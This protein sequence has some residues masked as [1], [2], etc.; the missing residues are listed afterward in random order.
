[1]NTKKINLL[2][3]ALFFY[4]I[5]SQSQTGDEVYL[6]LGIPLHL[7]IKIPNSFIIEGGYQVDINSNLITGTGI[8]YSSVRLNYDFHIRYFYFDRDVSTAYLFGGYKASISKNI[9]L[10]PKIQL[11][12]SFIDYRLVLFGKNWQRTS[13]ITINEEIELKLALSPRF[14]LCFLVNNS[15]VFTKFKFP[16]PEN[17]YIYRTNIVFRNRKVINHVTLKAGIKI[18][19]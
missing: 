1:M 6:N 14:N 2:L 15:T 5:T 10:I 18:D 11:G 9:S 13:G 3:L 4:P 17:T 12:Y 8:S 16:D 7:D 19:I